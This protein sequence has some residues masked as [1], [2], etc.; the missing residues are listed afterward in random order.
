LENEY[1]KENML[2]LMEYILI[3]CQYNNVEMLKLLRRFYKNVKGSYNARVL[4]EP[5]SIKECL[6][7]AWVKSCVFN[8]K[9]NSCDQDINKMIYDILYTIKYD[10]LPLIDT[11]NVNY[12]LV[13]PLIKWRYKNG[14]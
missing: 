6:R 13:V 1:T 11:T 5:R 14:I 3:E 9:I 2:N 4:L 12:Q 10:E 7:E 8:D